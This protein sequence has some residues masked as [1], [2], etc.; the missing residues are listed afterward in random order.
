MELI[1]IVFEQF[2]LV[3]SLQLPVRSGIDL[4]LNIV[5]FIELS[6]MKLN[7]SYNFKYNSM[8]R[9]D[10]EH[11]TFTQHKNKELLLNKIRRNNT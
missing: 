6:L 2:V 8:I 3:L 11:I 9:R 7:G 1:D 5:I 4:H 10:H